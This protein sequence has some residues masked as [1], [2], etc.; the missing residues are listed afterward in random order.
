MTRDSAASSNTGFTTYWLSLSL[1]LLCTMVL[2][3]VVPITQVVWVSKCKIAFACTEHGLGAGSELGECW[4]FTF[5][6]QTGKLWWWWPAMKDGSPRKPSR[7]AGHRQA[8]PTYLG[9]ISF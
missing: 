5:I 9:S 1:G 4:F 3:T 8:A 6:T 2:T 7:M